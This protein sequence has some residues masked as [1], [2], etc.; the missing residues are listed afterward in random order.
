MRLVHQL[1]QQ[2][3]RDIILASSSM[4]TPSSFI[5][6]LRGIASEGQGQEA[7]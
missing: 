1:S 6:Q 5:D 3:G 7:Y 4:E 2:L